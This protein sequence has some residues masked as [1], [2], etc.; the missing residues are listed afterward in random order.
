MIPR[1]HRLLGALLIPVLLGT[2]GA[3][4]AQHEPGPEAKRLWQL[5]RAGQHEAVIREGRR[6]LDTGAGDATTLHHIVGRA[7]VA[8]GRYEPAV[9]QLRHALSP[10]PP[11]HSRA[12]SLNYMGR[13]QYQ[14]GHLAAADSAFRASRDMMATT[15]SA[16]SSGRWMRVLGFDAMY[17]AWTRAENDTIALFVS[18]RVEVGAERLLTRYQSAYESIVDGL[19]AALK[20]RVRMFVW[21]SADDAGKRRMEIGV[22]HPTY[23]VIHTA[24]GAPPGHELTHVVVDRALD[25][26]HQVGLIREGIAGALD[27][28]G[29]DRLQGARRAVAAADEP[30]SIRAWWAMG[31]DA[32][33]QIPERLRLSVAGAFVVHLRD[34]GGSE[35]LRR[36]LRDQRMERAR[37]IYGTDS[38]DRWIQSFEGRL[39]AGDA[40]Q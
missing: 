37:Q 31:A 2:G 11:P 1:F 22:A 12:W 17:E 6:L 40:G 38:L 18:P 14:L 15:R 5:Y 10:E 7:L 20:R 28:S 9:A 24:V 25:P 34:R 3:V 4:R 33:A 35:K 16:E 30:V 39:K 13:A 32:W 36:L 19:D 8:T 21:A 27:Q 29:R 23:A 26:S